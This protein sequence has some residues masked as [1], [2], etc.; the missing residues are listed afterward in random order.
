MKALRAW[1]VMVLLVVAGS[2]AAC[3]GENPILPEAP[4][5]VTPSFTE[6]GGPDCYHAVGS[7]VCVDIGTNGHWSGCPV[8]TNSDHAVWQPGG[9]TFYNPDH[10]MTWAAFNCTGGWSPNS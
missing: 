5:A 1:V 2:M 4:A 8:H 6:E 9:A 10:S 3:G 7:T